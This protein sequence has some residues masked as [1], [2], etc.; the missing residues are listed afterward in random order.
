MIKNIKKSFIVFFVAIGVLLILTFLKLITIQIIYPILAGSFLSVL[1]FVIFLIMF[2]YSI[3]KSNKF[4][5]LFSIGGIILRLFIMLVIVFV[6]L[7][8]LK[9]DVF[10]FIFTFFLWYVFFMV[11]EISIVQSK[12]KNI[13]TKN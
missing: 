5:L 3:Q 11:F 7:K 6:V 10:G 1:N 8:F 4:F 13:V 12:T 2:Y 9:I